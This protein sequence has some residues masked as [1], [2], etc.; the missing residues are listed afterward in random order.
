LKSSC[1][2][3]AGKD[4]YKFVFLTQPL[5]NRAAFQGSPSLFCPR[6]T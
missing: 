1:D 2:V 6:A 5:L 3:F 4:F